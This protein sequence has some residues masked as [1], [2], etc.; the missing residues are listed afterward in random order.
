[1]EWIERLVWRSYSKASTYRSSQQEK[2]E[3][4]DEIQALT[5]VTQATS[6]RHQRIGEFSHC[7]ERKGFSLNTQNQEQP[8]YSMNQVTTLPR[9]SNIRNFVILYMRAK[10]NKTPSSR[11]FHLS[12]KRTTM[13]WGVLLTQRNM[14]NN[15]HTQQKK[16]KEARKEIN[17][18]QTNM[19]GGS[20]PESKI[21]SSRPCLFSQQVIQ[22]RRMSPSIAKSL[23]A[24][25]TRR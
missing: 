6:R 18:K 25:P 19:Q 10:V 15:S 8:P 24:K 21:D 12:L 5:K 22:W 17:S 3:K 2:H 7:F 20:L 14:K 13:D 4:D 1:M 11:C 9:L 23:T 16:A